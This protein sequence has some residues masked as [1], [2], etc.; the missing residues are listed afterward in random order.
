MELIAIGADPI[1]MSGTF[2]V[3]PKPTGDLVLAGIRQELRRAHLDGIRIVCSSEKNFTVRQTGI[4]IT[5]MGLV[6]N[7]RI[8]CGR[9]EQGDE[10]AAIGE[11]CVGR[12]VVHGERSKRIADT[13][14][15]LKLRKLA[16]VHELIPVGSKGIL[17]EAN[18]LAG[19]SGLYFRP[20]EPQTVNLRKSAGP[21]TVLVV[22]LEEGSFPRIRRAVQKPVRRIGSLIARQQGLHMHR[23]QK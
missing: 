18:V 1:V 21:T 9:C 12:E 20:S 22:A 14:D 5:A 13:L 10:V 6:P 19:D 11:P 3:E 17:Y 7:T 15:A 23:G 4:G 16:C 8:S 2:C